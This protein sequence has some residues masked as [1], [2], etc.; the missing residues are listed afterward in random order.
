[1]I[2][3]DTARA[4]QGI[5]SWKGPLFISSLIIKVKAESILQNSCVSVKHANLGS[6][7]VFV[8]SFIAHSDRHTHALNTHSHPTTHTH[9]QKSHT[10][11]PYESK[12]FLSAQVQAH[13][14]NRG[15]C[16][17]IH[18]LFFGIWL[19]YNYQPRTCWA[20]FFPLKYAALSFQ[21]CFG[22]QRIVI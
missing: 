11:D 19:L 13:P 3:T 15:V 21:H 14:P 8:A 1:M 22:T 2:K 9:T 6:I 7:H 10:Q 4:V 17:F 18:G 16:T 20:F 5:A 12:T